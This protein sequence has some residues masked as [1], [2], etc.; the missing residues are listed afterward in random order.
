MKK[1]IVLGIIFGLVSSS[2]G[3]K[4]ME[5]EQQESATTGEY[6]IEFQDENGNDV[7]VVCFL[8]DSVKVSDS[9]DGEYTYMVGDNEI[10][11]HMISE[12]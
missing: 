11:F 3:H 2:C 4:I 9:G 8:D 7:E 6:H 10:S 5:P 12:Q 1:I